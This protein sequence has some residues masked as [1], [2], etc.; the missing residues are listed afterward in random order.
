MAKDFAIT[1]NGDLIIDKNTHDFAMI[2]GVDEVAQR[3][4]ATLLI[5]YGE[6]PNL[7]PEQGSDYSNFIGKNFNPD[8]ARADM[9][10]T[11]EAN[12]PEVETLDSIEFE[13]LPERGL[14]VHFKATVNLDGNTETAEGG[15]ELGD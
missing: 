2:D 6:M 3:I 5:R 1:F 14:A 9:R 15:F 7:A 12:V 11:I 8:L 13:K 4:R 10:A